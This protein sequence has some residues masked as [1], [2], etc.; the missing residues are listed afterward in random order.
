MSVLEW[1]LIGELVLITAAGMFWLLSLVIPSEGEEDPVARFYQTFWRVLLRRRGRLRSVVNAMD[2]EKAKQYEELKASGDVEGI[3]EL[4]R[5]EL[6][7]TEF[8]DTAFGEELGAEVAES[9]QAVERDSATDEGP[10][11]ATVEVTVTPFAPREE[12]KAFSGR[13]AVVNV[14]CGPEDGQANKAVIELIAAA[15]NVKAY[16]LTLVK[17]HYRAYKTVQVAGMDQAQVEAKAATFA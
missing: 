1:M 14:T 12:L 11:V 6:G 3:K 5:E 4:L 7:E 9:L 15:L 16:Q 13:N 8:N 2:I 10:R 17:G